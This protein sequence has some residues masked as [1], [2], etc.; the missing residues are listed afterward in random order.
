MNGRLSVHLSHAPAGR[1]LGFDSGEKGSVEIEDVNTIWFVKAKGRDSEESQS[2]ST[3]SS[4]IEDDD[5]KRVFSA[6]C[7]ICDGCD[8][9]R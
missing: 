3:Q 2:L 9:G 5:E 8:A 6:S 4:N 1:T 7:P